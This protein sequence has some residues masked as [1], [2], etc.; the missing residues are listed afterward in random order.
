MYGYQVIAQEYFTMQEVAKKI[1]IKGY[2]RSNIF[3]LLKQKNILDNSNQPLE[4]FARLGYFK[5]VENIVIP[6]RNKYFYS[7]SCRVS[8]SGIG[9]I[10]ALIIQDN[11]SD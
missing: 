9:F 11:C 8:L 10:K 6:H 7:S 3:K 4:E 1:N 5:P 2:G